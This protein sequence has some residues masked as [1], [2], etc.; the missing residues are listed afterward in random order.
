[1]GLGKKIL[2]A[3]IL[4]ECCAHFKDGDERDLL[5]FWIYGI[6]YMLHIYF[7]FSGYSDMAI[8]LGRILGFEFMENFRYPYISTSITEFWRRWHI[9]LGT[10]FKD[11]VYIPLGG[12]RVSKAV[13]IRNIMVVWFLTGFWHGASWNF[14]LWGMFFACFLLLEKQFLSVKLKNS[15]VLSRI[16]VLFFIMVSFIIFDSVELGQ[17]VRNIGGL[18]GIGVTGIISG[19]SIYYGKSY[20]VII[21]I[22]AVAATPLGNVVR[23]KW[24]GH[25]VMRKILPLGELAG[26]VII[27]LLCTAYLVDGSF[28]PFLYFRF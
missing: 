6:S 4:G 14:I 9:S 21:I 3:N 27:L 24:R 5:F 16:Y 15:L 19:E 23:H 11:Y 2:I 28:N 8:G 12:N 7:D 20:L 26:A 10:W 22:A 17:A 13:W 18:F 25:Q 1:M